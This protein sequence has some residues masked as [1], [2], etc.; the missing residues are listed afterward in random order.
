MWCVIC[1]VQVASDVSG[2]SL[3]SEGVGRGAARLADRRVGQ[4][5]PRR[6]DAGEMSRARALHA[7]MYDG[8]SVTHFH[9]VGAPR[10][11]SREHGDAAGA[12]GL[13]TDEQG[14]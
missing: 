3:E 7:E 13:G 9:A 5:S 2:L 11:T 6:A 4:P 1:P 8:F 14:A 10:L 12:A